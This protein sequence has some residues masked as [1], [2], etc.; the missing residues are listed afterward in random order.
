MSI[1]ETLGE[2]SQGFMRLWVRTLEDFGRGL[3]GICETLGED[4]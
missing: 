4:S 3:A 2:D 1:C